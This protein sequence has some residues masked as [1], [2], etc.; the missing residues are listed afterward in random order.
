[1]GEV[2]VK[3]YTF[4]DDIREQYEQYGV[5]HFPWMIEAQLQECNYPWDDWEVCRRIRP[6][7]Q[8]RRKLK[9]QSQAAER[10]QDKRK[11]GP[12]P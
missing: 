7:E 5:W 9:H 12:S 2:I 4:A 1:M 6:L 11:L 3:Q 10:K 8:T